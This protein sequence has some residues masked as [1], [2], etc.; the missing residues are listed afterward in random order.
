ETTATG[1]KI[2]RVEEKMASVGEKMLRLFEGELSGLAGDL[3]E[4]DLE[5]IR[6]VTRGIALTHGFGVWTCRMLEPYLKADDRA[7]NPWEVVNEDPDLDALLEPFAKDPAGALAVQNQ[8]AA[9]VILTQKNERFRELL[10]ETRGLMDSHDRLV[11]Q[12]DLEKRIQAARNRWIRIFEALDNAG[13]RSAAATQLDLAEW[14][15]DGMQVS[16]AESPQAFADRSFSMDTKDIRMIRRVFAGMFTKAV[17][18]SSQGGEIGE[19]ERELRDLLEQ[20]RALAQAA[21]GSRLTSADDG[22]AGSKVTES[23]RR[24]RH[25]IRDVFRLQVDQRLAESSRLR[26]KRELWGARRI[27]SRMEAELEGGGAGAGALLYDMYEVIVVLRNW[28][29]YLE[30]HRPDETHG[31][32]DPE[33]IFAMTFMRRA[34]TEANRV[35]RILDEYMEEAGGAGV[36]EGRDFYMVLPS[37]AGLR[38]LMDEARLRQ[39]AENPRLKLPEGFLNILRWLYASD[40]PAAEEEDRFAKD[41]VSLLEDGHIFREA[42]WQMTDILGRKPAARP[43]AAPENLAKRRALAQA[44][45]Q[46]NP[47]N[48]REQNGRRDYLVRR[49]LRETG[50]AVVHSGEF[51]LRIA[52][53]RLIEFGLNLNE[54]SQIPDNVVDEVLDQ[55][56]KFLNNPPNRSEVRRMLFKAY[57][58][59]LEEYH[60]IGAEPEA[61]SRLAGDE[62]ESVFGGR[63][64][65]FVDAVAHAQPAALT[66]P[67]AGEPGLWIQAGPGRQVRLNYYL[68]QGRLRASVEGGDWAVDVNT[69]AG[70]GI[71]V[72]RTRSLSEP[73][74]L[75]R[76]AN[77]RVFDGVLNSATPTAQVIALYLDGLVGSDD[78]AEERLRNLMAETARL[79]SEAAGVLYGRAENVR[80]FLEGTYTCDVYESE[81]EL[82][83]RFRDCTRVNLMSL[84]VREQIGESM[85]DGFC[86]TLKDPVSEGGEAEVVVYRPLLTLARHAGEVR[87]SSVNDPAMAA[88]HDFYRRTTGYDL[89]LGDFTRLLSGDLALSRKYPV[90]HV[91]RLAVE[92]AL[93]LYELMTHA[94]YRSA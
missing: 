82:P 25:A 90:P 45:E 31:Q 71:P 94:T 91:L 69:A 32:F 9:A 51:D 1:R 2:R 88:M 65:F 27:M 81:E 78:L 40:Q 72:S 3:R 52:A 60:M 49:I 11:D 68:D 44:L 47:E 53:D 64:K 30:L 74:R 66:G 73:V 87:A 15:L 4:P 26:M 79:P 86:L 50:L 7:R 80:A 18:R 67:R 13:Y 16:R 5:R 59:F 57:E 43:N 46:K 33:W 76:E 77:E 63:L 20:Y 62:A 75:F 14:L 89:T 85:P 54:A 6:S 92:E 12:A 21:E 19:A 42:L 37:K 93:R 39:T 35:I 58:A 23:L 70:R 48:R 83:G 22:A 38:A 56:W 34:A 8:Y 84:S 61:G 17:R 29:E 10:F 55:T 24:I 28:A 41:V 36:F